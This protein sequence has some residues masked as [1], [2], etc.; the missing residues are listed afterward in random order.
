MGLPEELLQQLLAR[1]AVMP[2][3]ISKDGAERS[4]TKWVVSRDRYM[5]FAQSC[6][7]RANVAS[8]LMINRIFKAA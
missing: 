6:C 4:D 5:M 1:Q 8:R 2:F 3:D 7:C